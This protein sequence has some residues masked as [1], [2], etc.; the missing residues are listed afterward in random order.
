[1]KRLFFDIETLPAEGKD[2]EIVKQ[3]WEDVKKKSANSEKKT[4]NNFDN[5]FRNTSFQGEFGRILCIGYAIEGEPVE[6][7]SGDEKEI[8]KNFWEIAKDADLFIGHN[9][10]EFDL[11]FIYKR[12][13]IHNIKPSRELNFARYRNNPIYDTMK[14]WEKWGAI[15]TSLHKLSICLGVTSPKEAGIDGSKVYDFYLDGKADEIYKYCKRDV[16]ATRS[17]YE[18]MTFM[19]K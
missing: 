4:E 13:I 7:L 12:S 1:M 11:R 16:E 5:F 18:R 19:T 17:V 15:G 14:E 8:L 3:L 10:M 9:I 6:C 2:I